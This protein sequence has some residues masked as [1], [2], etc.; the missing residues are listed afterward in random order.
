MTNIFRLT[1]ICLTIKQQHNNNE[2]NKKEEKKL[3]QSV[4]AVVEESIPHDYANKVLIKYPNTPLN[5][6]IN[7]RYGKTYNKEVLGRILE[8]CN[9]P[10]PTFLAGQFYETQN[11]A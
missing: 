3:C 10:V 9:I 4:L 6:L 11:A 7:V 8:T 5:T 2:M 1:Y